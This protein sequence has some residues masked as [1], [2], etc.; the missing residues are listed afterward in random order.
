MA[1]YRATTKASG[2]EGVSVTLTRDSYPKSLAEEDKVGMLEGCRQ[3]AAFL[4]VAVSSM[5]DAARDD[6]LPNGI[7]MDRVTLG[8]EKCCD[9]LLD[10]LGMLAGNS[11]MPLL[12]D[13]EA[14]HG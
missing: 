10:R 4:K 5:L 12:K 6:S 9:L 2:T 1:D 14:R 7:E 11:P 13:M 8:Y 3:I